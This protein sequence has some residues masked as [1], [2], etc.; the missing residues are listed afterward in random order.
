MGR[1]AGARTLAACVAVSIPSIVAFLAWSPSGFVED[2]IRFPLGLGR[3]LSV[4]ETPTLGA[5]L[6]R[7]AAHAFRTP[8]T[9]MLV[10]AVAALAIG[11]LI[12][13][14]PATAA[15]AAGATGLVFLSAI[16]LAP[17]ART[18]YVV[19]PVNLLAWWW[20]L[21]RP[22]YVRGHPTGAPGA[23]G[24]SESPRATL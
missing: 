9:I 8:L 22:A 7:L 13:Q 2:A 20:L 18:G 12:R 10:G 11:I 3:E 23:P 1:R 17:A 24:A 5:L 4:A 15:A 19:Y 16:L 21:R 14:P 6:V